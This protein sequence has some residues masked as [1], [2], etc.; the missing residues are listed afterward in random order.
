MP[1]VPKN[2]KTIFQERARRT[3]DQ[4][5]SA[6]R[7]LQVLRG[8]DRRVSIP[9]PN[10]AETPIVVREALVDYIE[11]L[12]EEEK[13][14]HL[15]QQSSRVMFKCST[16]FPFDFFP[17]KII[18]DEAKLNIIIK[19]FFATESIHSVMIKN[20]KDIQIQSSIFFA[21]VIIIPDIYTSEPISVGYLRKKD[22]Y[23][24]RR[25]VQGIL[26]C[27]R[28]GIDLGKLDVMEFKD[29]VRRVGT[30]NTV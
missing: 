18:L 10:N 4:I 8:G 24:M 1:S 13:L 9:P 16:V 3:H 19:E 26:V 29:K 30:S 6:K 22:A 17:D 21:T 5:N 23:E 25:L 14:D 12:E 15:M 28:E 11:K 27:Q 7:R 20:I 2:S